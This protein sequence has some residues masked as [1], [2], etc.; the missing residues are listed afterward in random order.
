MIREY[1]AIG[2]LTAARMMADMGRRSTASCDVELD[3]CEEELA[4]NCSQED[5]EDV[6]VGSS[7]EP[8]TWVVRGIGKASTASC[9]TQLDCCEEV[10]AAKCSQQDQEDTMAE[11]SAE[12]LAWVVGDV[13]RQSTA[14]CDTQLDSC[15]ERLATKCSQ[16]DH[17][18][19]TAVS[20][21]VSWT[22]PVACNLDEQTDNHMLRIDRKSISSMLSG[23]SI[24]IRPEMSSVACRQYLSSGIEFRPQA[25]FRDISVDSYHEHN[26][27]LPCSVR[28][29]VVAAT[30]SISSNCSCNLSQHSLHHQQHIQLRPQMQQ[31]QPLSAADDLLVKIR[32]ARRLSPTL[33]AMCNGVSGDAALLSLINEF[34]NQYGQAIQVLQRLRSMQSIQSEPELDPFA[35]AT[36]EAEAWGS[37]VKTRA[38]QGDCNSG[39]RDVAQAAASELQRARERIQSAGI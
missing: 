21:H 2:V 23:G 39:L 33:V 10:L 20:S 26:A 38:A 16:E 15:E 19:V 35:L 7:A 25:G 24:Q 8:P 29:H 34:E 31:Q 27:Y 12:P 9:D 17:Q 11:S 22:E 6:I 14:S 5:Q 1:E 28:P 37:L 4:A 32:V 36:C 18:D 3:C 30:C 13:G